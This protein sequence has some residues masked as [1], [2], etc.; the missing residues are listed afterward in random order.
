[1]RRLQWRSSGAECI[2]P[3]GILHC[4]LPRIS[5]QRSGR[6]PSLSECPVS[7]G[8][9]DR[10][11][12][13]T[14]FGRLPSLADNL[15]QC[16]CVRRAFGH[17]FESTPSLAAVAALIGL[18]LVS[19]EVRLRSRQTNP[20]SARVTSIVVDGSGT[21]VPEMLFTKVLAELVCTTPRDGTGIGL[22][23]MAVNM[24]T[25]LLRS[26]STLHGRSRRQISLDVSPNRSDDCHDRNPVK[27]KLNERNPNR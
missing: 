6:K 16:S 25:H 5:A 8:V 27:E 4:R 13:Q 7:S 17:L 14:I 1:M 19:R 23:G 21:E 3:L 12:T 20:S 15:I 2:P 22:V 10:V 24:N 26:F 11:P 9:V 18:S